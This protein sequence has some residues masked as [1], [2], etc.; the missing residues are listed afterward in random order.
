L[1]AQELTAFINSFLTPLTDIIIESGGT[2]DKYMGDAIMAFWNAP[3]D[4]A[5]HAARACL[6]SSQIQARMSELNAGWRRD[7]EAAGRRFDDVRIGIGLNTGECCVGNL[8][9]ERRFDYSAIGD[10]VNIASRLEGLTKVYGLAL[11]VSEETAQQAATN[12]FIEVDIVR[13]KGREGATRVFTAPGAPAA[14]EHSAFLEAY[15]AG[16]FDEAAVLLATLAP[17]SSPALRG[18]YASYGARLD[19]LRH[20]TP[21]QWD[22]VYDPQFK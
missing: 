17:A 21:A 22:G 2:I 5:D 7:A 14:P 6:A 20:S 19:G 15:R 13:L 18:L 16:R 11:L 1:N 12:D 3:L 10:A 4:Q 9:S 8:G